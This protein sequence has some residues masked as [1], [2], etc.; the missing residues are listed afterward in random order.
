MNKERKKSFLVT[1]LLVIALI[2]VFVTGFAGYELI[3]YNVL[4][5]EKT[6]VEVMT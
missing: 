5:T 1:S 2:L 6:G 3:K 4:T